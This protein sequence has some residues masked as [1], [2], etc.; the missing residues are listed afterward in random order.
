LIDRLSD[1]P[2][3]KSEKSIRIENVP[4]KSE[5]LAEVSYLS[6]KNVADSVLS[7]TK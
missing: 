1:H 6:D 2:D 7:D 3:N 5:D 4:N